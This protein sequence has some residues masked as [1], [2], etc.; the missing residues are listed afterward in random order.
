MSDELI[1]RSSEITD[2]DPKLR[3]IDLIAVPY[4]EEADVIWRGEDWRESFDRSAFLGIEEHAGR[5]RVNREHVK[6][7]TVGK[8]VSLTPSDPVGLRAMVK[9]AKS[10]RGDDTLALAEEDMISASVG[11]RVR[12]PADVR[13][14]PRTRVRRVMRAFLDH[15]GLV[16]SP[17][18]AGAQVLA[19][20]DDDTPAEV[21]SP[22]PATPLLDA[23]RD[24]ELFDW[25]ATRLRK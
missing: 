9:I 3:L 17:A 19:V 14:H 8:V 16:E 13:F 20:R 24:D 7:D 15:L 12:R 18:Y 21:L 10:A 2:V 5:V 23:L 25:V 11:Y 6:G 4:D 1:I 22:L